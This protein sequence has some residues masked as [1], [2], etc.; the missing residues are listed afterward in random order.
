VKT[1]NVWRARPPPLP[2]WA[3]MKRTRT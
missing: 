1:W 3:P 2:T